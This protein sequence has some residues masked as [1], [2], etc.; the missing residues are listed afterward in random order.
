MFRDVNKHYKQ[1]RRC[2]VLYEILMTHSDRSRLPAQCQP[3]YISLTLLQT[4]E[5]VL[6]PDI[7]LNCIILQGEPS[8][9]IK[10]MLAVI[11]FLD[12]TDLIRIEG[13]FNSVQTPSRI[14][15]FLI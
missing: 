10:Q 6:H 8:E 11:L 15:S 9:I 12:T 7:Q 5:S 3:L 1:G 13:S 4:R 2:K 14:E